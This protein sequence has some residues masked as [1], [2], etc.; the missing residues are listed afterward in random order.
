MRN[1]K[2]HN[3]SSILVLSHLLHSLK[4]KKKIKKKRKKKKEKEKEKERYTSNTS[5]IGHT[6][7]KLSQSSHTCQKQTL[8][9]LRKT[10]YQHMMEPSILPR[11][12]VLFFVFVSATHFFFFSFVSPASVSTCLSLFLVL[13]HAPESRK[14]VSQK[15]SDMTSKQNVWR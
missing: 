4:I 15:A 11:F 3:Q 13:V 5:F 7:K 1:R 9:D 8:I 6:D 14:V 12:F 10:K 2:W